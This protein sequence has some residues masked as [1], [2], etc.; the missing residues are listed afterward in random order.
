MSEENKISK[1]RFKIIICIYCSIGIS[2]FI[3]IH[4]MSSDY[5]GMLGDSPYNYPL[6]KAIPMAI[7]AGL[8]LGFVNYAIL[9]FTK[10]K[11]HAILLPIAIMILGIFFFC[12]IQG[13]FNAFNLIYLF[14]LS[15]VVMMAIK[16]KYSHPQK[17]S[18]SI[19]ALELEHKE[20]LQH[21]HFFIWGF[22]V[23]VIGG[24]FTSLMASVEEDFNVIRYQV[25]AHTFLV[26]YYVIGIWFGTFSKFLKRLKQI[27]ME[28]SQ[29]EH[30]SPPK[31]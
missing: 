3:I 23:V 27:R 12:L 6:S 28:I 20:I 5:L 9:R 11:H 17:H 26:I 18:S 4:S 21:I 8:I 1:A 13:A 14:T 15:V 2:M 16:N 29:I 22:I 30:T 19:R 31:V 10:T 25:I 24:L 7:I